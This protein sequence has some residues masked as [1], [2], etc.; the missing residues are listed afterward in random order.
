MAD[1]GL[2]RE[3]RCRAQRSDPG[4]KGAR[5]TQG[6]RLGMPPRAR[7]FV[8]ATPPTPRSRLHRCRAAGRP[9][10]QG[11]AAARDGLSIQLLSLGGLADGHGQGQPPGAA[12]ARPGC[13]HAFCIAAMGPR[14]M[15]RARP[16][17]RA[18][19]NR[20]RFPICAA[21]SPDVAAACQ[22]GAYPGGFA[23]RLDGR[24]GCPRSFGLAGCA[25]GASSAPA[26]AGGGC[27]H[28]ARQC[29]HDA[30]PFL[31]GHP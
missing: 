4:R 6:E 30:P 20:F 17:A 18:V 10:H 29:V 12:A 5:S 21:R 14:P 1:R 31:G 26:A 24:P 27:G 2:P 8:P 25:C 22:C 3:A 28:A 16:V 11:K 19:Q 23:R 7:P 9:G 13:A 15:A